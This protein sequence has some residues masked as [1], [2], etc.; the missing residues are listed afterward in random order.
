MDKSAKRHSSGSAGS[1]MKAAKAKKAR[2]DG[3]A[4]AAA[5]P[6]RARAVQS[7][8]EKEEPKKVVQGSEK[9]KIKQADKEGRK[10]EL[11]NN[12]AAGARTHA[13]VAAVAVQHALR[14]AAR[15][16]CRVCSAAAAA[17]S[18]AQQ[19]RPGQR[20]QARHVSTL[21]GLTGA[22]SPQPWV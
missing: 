14:R 12:K 8:Q 2:L 19:V 7:Q 22:T 11:H 10:E 20:L 6:A 9:R 13:A 4:A 5:V 1:A 15:L 21:Q 16:S 18:T 3:A 17:V